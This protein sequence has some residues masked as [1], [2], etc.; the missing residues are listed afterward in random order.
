MKIQTDF[1]LENLH[2]FNF[3][4]CSK[5]Q[6]HLYSSVGYFCFYEALYLV[7]KAFKREWK[8]LKVLPHP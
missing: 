3:K 1:K 6:V 7:K 5:S 2:F 8:P 4:I